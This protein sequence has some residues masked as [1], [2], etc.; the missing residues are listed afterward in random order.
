MRD[1]K[2][3]MSLLLQCRNQVHLFKNYFLSNIYSLDVEIFSERL[4]NIS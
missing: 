2:I 1:R 4:D 3:S